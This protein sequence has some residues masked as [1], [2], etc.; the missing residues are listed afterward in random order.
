MEACRALCSRRKRSRR[1]CRSSSSAQAALSISTSSATSRQ[2][3]TLNAGTPGKAVWPPYYREF[4]LDPS[5]PVQ[6]ANRTPFAEIHCELIEELRPAVASFHFGLP[7]ERLLARVKAAGCKV[8]SSA[9]TVAEARW[10][11]ARGVDAIIAQGA[12]A[13]GHRGMFLTNDVMAQPGT[14]ALVPQVADA[15]RVP[16]IASG[17]IADGRGIAAA[18]AL[19]ASGVQVGTAFLFCPGAKLPAPHARAL[20]EARD[21]GTVVTNVL[22]GRPA[23]GFYNRAIQDLGPMAADASEFPSAATALA[24]LRVQAEAQ[25]LGDFSPPWAGQAAPLGRIMRAQE[26]TRSLAL[27]ALAVVKALNG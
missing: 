12:E 10:L 6:A 21:D 11:E 4:G 24:P 14:F 16:V 7:E 26:L 25:G 17:G 3:R 13:G 22:T 2:R 15:V 5:A 27:E 1:R 9:T 18:F 20:G 19:G 8:L 23:R